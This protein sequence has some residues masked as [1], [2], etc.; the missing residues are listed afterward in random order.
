[1]AVETSGDIVFIHPELND[2]LAILKTSPIEKLKTLAEDRNVVARR[3]SYLDFYKE[4]LQGH[5][6]IT[7]DFFAL[8]EIKKQFDVIF[9]LQRFSEVADSEITDFRE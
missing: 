4:T 5:T 1:M 2:F 6:V 9:Q 3:T 7:T 8:Y